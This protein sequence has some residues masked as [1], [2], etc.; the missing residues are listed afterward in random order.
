MHMKI[1]AGILLVALCAASFA[2]AA[3]MPKSG[4]FAAQFGWVFKGD[5]QDLGANRA[6]SVGEVSGVI[7]NN[8]GG[9]FLHKVRADCALMNDVDHGKANAHGTCAMTDADGDKA[10]L[11]WKC[12][13]PMPTCPGDQRFVGGTGKYKGLSGDTK[14]QGNFIGKSGAGWSDWSGEY[15]IP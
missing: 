1:G 4:K 3:D 12:A 5:T 14:F 10:F 15:R 8:S 2:S 6:V 9:G 11:E 7:F 13:G